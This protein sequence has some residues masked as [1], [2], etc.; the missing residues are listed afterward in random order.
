[1]H[2]PAQRRTTLA[3]YPG[4]PGDGAAIDA[5]APHIPARTA[6][7][8]WHLLSLDAPTV[9][10]TWLLFA[11]NCSGQPRNLCTAAALFLAVWAIYIGDRILDA[12]AF[13]SV[14]VAGRASPRNLRRA[15]RDGELQLRHHFHH[16]HGKAFTALL[17]GLMPVLGF[18]L[19]KLPLSTLL[20]EAVL[21]VLLAVWLLRVHGPMAHPHPRRLPKE[22]VV[23]LFFAAAVYLP[24]CFSTAIRNSYKLSL[25]PGAALFAAVCTLNCLFLHLW[26]QPYEL[27]DIDPDT[28]PDID[29]PHDLARAHIVTRFATRRLVPIA[30]ATLLA[31]ALYVS[32]TRS[33][34]TRGIPLACAL[35]T[36]LLLT[37]HANCHRF[38][39]LRLRALADLVLL[40]PVLV[41]IAP[42]ATGAVPF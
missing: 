15:T 11:D 26:E 12:N 1:M 31:S 22:F 18:L 8:F 20:P 10:V 9:A 24:A 37:L 16:R 40:T 41:W 39:P 17:A 38:S 35:S 3:I 19:F 28:D 42:H 7:D 6:L 23:G 25:L 13:F 4:V 5:R 29:E 34:P 21:A 2:M 27:P 30:S 36:A 14:G 32:L 33:A